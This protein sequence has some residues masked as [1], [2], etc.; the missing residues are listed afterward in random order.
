MGSIN[1][2]H[3]PTWLENNRLFRWLFLTRK[4]YLSKSGFT[5]HAQ[6]AEDITIHHLFGNRTGFFVDVGC[7]H[8]KKHSNTWAL[9]KRGW[10]GIN[11]DIDSIKIA[12]FNRVRPEDINIACAISNVEGEAT[13][14]SDGFYSLTVTMDAEFA[15]RNNRYKPKTTACKRLDSIIDASPYK[16]REIDFLTVD[17]EAHDMEVLTSLDFDRYKP[18]LVAVE[19]HHPLFSEV[20]ESDI[21]RFLIEKNYCLVG[22]CGL[23]L[24]MASE[25][26]QQTLEN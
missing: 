7:F 18:K 12:A 5:H 23:T 10:R 24:L 15:S 26:L 13:Y 20:C 21:Y 19:S 9:Y 17:A 14:Y 25:I 2:K 11:I 3:L 6:F 22:W 4:L 8:P 16:D 1:Y